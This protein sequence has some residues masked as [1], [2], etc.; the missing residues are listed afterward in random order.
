VGAEPGLT[1]PE[2]DGRADRLPRPPQD[3]LQASAPEPP[4]A[5]SLEE[6]LARPPRLDRG[7]DRLQASQRLLPG[8]LRALGIPTRIVLCIPVV[9][10]SDERQ[11]ALAGFR[12]FKKHVFGPPDDPSL[13]SIIAYELVGNDLLER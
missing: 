5:R 8:C 7:A 12:I 9:D 3:S 13:H 6:G 4:Q 1:R 11:L 2:T 10:A